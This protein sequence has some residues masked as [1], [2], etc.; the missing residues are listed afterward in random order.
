MNIKWLI[1]ASAFTFVSVAQAADIVVPPSPT[2][3][4]PVIVAPTFS[5]TGFYIGGQIGGFSSKTKMDILSK[6]KTIPVSD[7]FLP[8]LSGFMGGL[9]AGSNVDLGNGLIL[10]VDTDIIWTDKDDTKTVPPYEIAENHVN[11]VNKM[12]KD[13]GINIGDNKLEAGKYTRALGFTFKEKWAGATRVR[14]G[15]AAE[16]IMPY[17]AGGIAYTQLQDIT[18]ISITKK[19]TGKVIASGNLSDET[20]TLVGYTLGAGVDLAMT[21]NVIVRAEYRY[22]DFGKK[23]FSNDKYE[24]SY[25]TND[26]RVGVAYKF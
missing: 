4:A 8:K 7:D 3:V 15:F 13:A 6:G 22:S 18:S 17:V 14:I 10:G 1:T 2:P 21:N 5:W 23:K 12:L 24:T 25:K 9:Y 26:F 11:Y 19:E 20:K 16:R